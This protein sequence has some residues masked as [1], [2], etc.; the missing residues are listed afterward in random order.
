MSTKAYPKTNQRFVMYIPNSLRQEVESWVCQRAM[1]L[2]EFGREA[3]EYY[4][5]NK[6]REERKKQLA[7]TCRLFS[8]INDDI[9]KEWARA[10][11]ESWST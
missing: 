6:K 5:D 9:L 3:F 7:E 4:L 1:T 10:E 8:D 2:A 11:T